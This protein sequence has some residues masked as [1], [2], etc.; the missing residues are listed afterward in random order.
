MKGLK[1]IA[2][3]LSL[4]VIESKQFEAIYESIDDTV[5]S[6]RNSP[7]NLRRPS[8]GVLSVPVQDESKYGY[9]TIRRLTSA[10]PAGQLRRGFFPTSSCVIPWDTITQV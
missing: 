6:P 1:S 5:L 2:G 7:P 4:K 8:N 9:T 10:Q 3:Y